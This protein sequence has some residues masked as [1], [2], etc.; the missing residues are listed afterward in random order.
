MDKS[1]IRFRKA[2]EED[3]PKLIKLCKETVV[4]VYDQILPR[5]KLESWVEGGKIA[6]MVNKQWQEM[7]VAERVG[8]IMGVAAILDDMV[9]FLWV[10][11]DHH[12]KGIGSALLDLVETEINRSGYELARLECFSD[13][14]RA[15]G[16]YQAKGYNPI[17]EDMDEDAGALK[18]VM[19][20][21]LAGS[22]V[23]VRI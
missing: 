4:R 8:E 6:E 7:I 23:D 22:P 14:Y 16:F 17:S 10:H 5:E 11:P 9:D 1:Q 2:T 19:T 15:M 20:K 18:K 12:R 13:N 3:V 21:S